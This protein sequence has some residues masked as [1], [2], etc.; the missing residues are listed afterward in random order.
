MDGRPIN[1][2]RR[3]AIA[4]LA[5]LAVTDTSHTRDHLAT[6]LWPDY[7]RAGSYAY[8]RRTLWELNQVLGRGWIQAD[9]ERVRMERNSDLWLDTAAFST[10]I[11]DD[12]GGKAELSEAVDIYRGDFLEGFAVAD[13]APF[14]DWQFQQCEYF[15]REYGETLR[16]LIEAHA[17]IK[18]YE[19]ALPYAQRWL[20]LDTL[21][22]A[23]HR[24]IMRILAGMGNRT[25]AIRQYETCVQVLKD[26]LGIGP[27]PE[28]TELYEAILRGE[29]RA[30]PSDLDTPYSIETSHT[31]LH[32]PVFPT[33]FIGRRAELE[34]V[35]ALIKE[36]THR[37]ISLVGPGGIGK[38]R[39]SVQAVSEV[40]GNFPD[41]VF[42]VPLGTVQNADA[43]LPAIAKAL[44]VSFF[45]EEEHPLQQLLAY[46]TDKRMLLILDNFEHLLD[47]SEFVCEL[48][49]QSPNLTV[50]VTSRIRLNV[51]G[52]QLYPV[53]GMRIAD[54]DEASTWEDPEEQSRLFSGVQLFLERARRI[55]PGF[56]LTQ[57][58]V[59]YVVR[60][61]QLVH[62]MPLGLEL[63]AAWLELLPPDE[64]A[65]EIARSLDFLETGQVDVPVR[66]RSIR[67]VFE[68]S[69]NLLSKAEQD[70]FLSLCVFVGSFSRAG[71]QQV[72]GASLRTLL[73]LAN[74]S[75]LQQT[76]DGRFQLHELMRQYGVERLQADPTAWEIARNRHA[77][78]IIDFVSEQKTRMQS[79]DQITG[80]RA[81]LDEYDTNVKL[82]WDWLIVQRHWAEMVDPIALCLCHF[83]MIRLR[84]DEFI[85]WLRSARLALN[86]DVSHEER[87]AYAIL[88]TAEIDCE[89]SSDI[90][91]ADPIERLAQIWQMVHQYDLAEDMGFWY[92]MLAGMAKDRRLSTNEDPKLDRVLA[93]LREQNKLWELGLSL[94]MHSNW[95]GSYD[96][97]E[98][99]LLEA[100]RIFEKTGV[101][102]EQG[103][104]AE[105]LASYAFQQRRPL[106]E[107]VRHYDHARHF[108]QQM[109]G[110]THTGSNMLHK[111]EVYFFQGDTKNGFGLFQSEQQEFEQL[112]QMRLFQSSLHL[113][114]LFAVRYSTFDHALRL[115]KNCMELVRKQGTQSELAW[116]FFELGDIYRIFGQPEKA[117]TNYEQSLPLAER[118]NMSLA[119]SFDQRARGDLALQAGHFTDAMLH[120]QEF[121][122]Y[123]RADNH[124]W[125]MT[126]SSARIAL[127]HAYLGNVD[128]AREAMRGVLKEMYEWRSDD[129]A[130]QC[131][132]AEAVCLL[133]EERME[134]AISMASFLQHSPISWNETRF[135]AD[136]IAQGCCGRAAG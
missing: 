9:R 134:D 30:A 84:S 96:L 42:F 81:L 25:G 86:P 29:V 60:I 45:K 56:G 47:A 121:D 28:T 120:Y 5:Y 68:S 130:M 114:G 72:S 90:R 89:V 98:E 80:V 53:S 27:Q 31:V 132:L 111:A 19:A 125:G 129:L 93:Q 10:L 127:A 122:R 43:V 83:G 95:W 82:A 74:K 21:N 1:T 48:L 76:E 112:G 126:Q 61:C 105:Q 118:M 46:L 100:A 41:G 133:K 99:M 109:R 38:T 57:E 88:S 119:L 16:K 102:Y 36:P 131:L 97:N 14:E 44:Q 115:R 113:E 20:A 12:P 66:Q 11:H 110:I 124:P 17:R 34:Q 37:L 65:A 26:H 117:M 7:D 58:T 108:Y 103:I 94:F 69:W 50:V 39:L 75:W 8:L 59:P 136:G 3:K 104:V 77:N 70:A 67:A 73:G 71:A 18:E 22:E 79:G 92:V 52:E 87:L 55:Q 33:T 101:I 54:S 49:K 32:L 128:Q 123:V 23:A 2:D 6:L 91:D 13:T 15:H 135:Q 116:Q 85:P 64:I 51:Q 78:Y 35:K 106:P 63:A 62:G 4:L 40:N 24:D 107:V